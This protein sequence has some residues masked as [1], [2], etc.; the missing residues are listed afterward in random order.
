MPRDAV[1]GLGVEPGVGQP[2]VDPPAAAPPGV[3]EQAVEV[4]CVGA[5]AGARL[6]REE[7]VSMPSESL[8]VRRAVALRMRSAERFPCVPLDEA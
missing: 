8:G 3:V 5:H 4:R 6:G 2:G 7:R 1:V